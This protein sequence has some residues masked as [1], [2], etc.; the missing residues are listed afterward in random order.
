MTTSHAAEDRVLGGERQTGGLWV[1]KGKF[2]AG[3]IG[4]SSSSSGDINA[5]RGDGTG[6]YFFGGSSGSYLYYTG[7]VFSLVGGPL[8]INTPGSIRTTDI[9]AN[10][11]QQLIGSYS[12]IPTW[13]T[14]AVSAWTATVVSTGSIACSGAPCRAECT[15]TLLHSAVSTW[16]TG[17][18]IDGVLQ[19]SL[20]VSNTA[21][22]I[23]TPVHW[24]VYHTPPAGNHT[25]ALA[26]YNA[27][28]GTLNIS[29][30][31]LSNLYV[32]EQKR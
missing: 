7:T 29:T 2:S 23:N 31:V 27:T 14:T 9:A 16:Y 10:A 30:A 26:V 5:N 17:L 18:M 24:S 11:V 22:N 20:T 25:F 4:T 28:A 32:T 6:A 12:A 19:Y 13:S 8:T 1:H 21:A 3:V 15:A